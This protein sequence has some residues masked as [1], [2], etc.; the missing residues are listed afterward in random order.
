MTKKK[1]NKH[2]HDNKHKN[3]DKHK[4]NDDETLR[5]KIQTSQNFREVKS[6]QSKILWGKIQILKCQ[7]VKSKHP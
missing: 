3:N 2:K 5:C 4:Q 1:K 7:C 6:R